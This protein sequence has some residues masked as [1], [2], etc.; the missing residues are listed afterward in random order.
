MVDPN[1]KILLFLV[2]VPNVDVIMDFSVSLTFVSLSHEKI[3]NK[4]GSNKNVTNI[5]I[6]NPNV[7]IQPKSIIGFIPLNT[8]D[9]KA[10]IVVKTV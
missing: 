2:K 6:I 10:H 7:I 5:E 9:K 1:I 8:K 4:E 3:F